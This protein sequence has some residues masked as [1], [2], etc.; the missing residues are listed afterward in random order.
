MVLVAIAVVVAAAVE[1]AIT[2]A[3]D[4]LSLTIVVKILLAK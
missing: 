4:L 3:A 2:A 1:T